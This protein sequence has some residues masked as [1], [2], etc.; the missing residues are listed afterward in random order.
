MKIGFIGNMNNNNFSLMRYFRDLGVDAHLLLASNDGEAGASHFKPES[1]TW[2]IERWQPYIHQTSLPNS[3]ISALSVPHSWVFTLVIG[4]Q[5]VVRRRASAS[6]PVSVRA[7][8][9]ALCEY[10][11]L[12]GSGI[13]PAML[14]R[15]GMRLDIFYPYAT[16]VEFFRTGLMQRRL[17]RGS[18][19][20]AVFLRVVARRQA[21]GLRLAGK[22]L[23]AEIGA[24]EEALL[25]I[26]VTPKRIAIPMVY[27][28]EKLPESAPSE[29]CKK[30]L[31]FTEESDISILHH[32]RLIWKKPGDLTWD[33]WAK[34]SKNNDWLF[35]GFADFIG[36]HPDSSARMVVVEYGPDVNSTKELA[37]EL[38]IS[39]RI[40][41]LPIL[42]RRELQWILSRVS[43]G[44]GEFYQAQRTIWGGTGWETL[45]SGTPL[46][47]G[48][49]FDDDEFRRSYGYPAPPLLAVRTQDDIVGHLI[50]LLE[51]PN[52]KAEIGRAAKSWFDKYNGLALAK[53]W[54]NVVITANE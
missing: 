49:N 29:S 28:G 39:R 11:V 52:K 4:A 15:A 44:V 7:I 42:T 8:K 43:V 34:S 13:A 37:D 47:Q 1:D 6:K 53:E 23:N 41:W 21:E 36:R 50:D 40:L 46:L 27:S 10:D 16:G 51:N 48:F 31:S 35:R 24:T 17:Q 22:V 33:E 12:I 19:F 38:G 14:G 9:K 3:L 25:E 54:L 32:A 30:V 45:A 5:W 26:G 18:I 2:E 20:D